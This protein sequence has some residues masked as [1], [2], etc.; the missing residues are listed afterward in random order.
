MVEPVAREASLYVGLNLANITEDNYPELR[1]DD[2]IPISWFLLFEASDIRTRQQVMPESISTFQEFENDLGFEFKFSDFMNEPVAFE[3]TIPKAQERLHKFKELFKEL[4]YFWSYFRVIDILEEHLEFQINRI[5][6]HNIEEATPIMQ[7]YHPD[8]IDSQVKLKDDIKSDADLM[9]LS[10]EDLTNLANLGLDEPS[11]PKGKSESSASEPNMD[12]DMMLD[13][14]PFAALMDDFSSALD[15]DAPEPEVQQPT[16]GFDDSFLLDSLGAALE[17]DTTLDGSEITEVAIEDDDEATAVMSITA[18]FDHLA[19]EGYGDKIHKIFERI[20]NLYHHIKREEGKITRIMIDIFQDIFR[21]SLTN[22]R[23][24]G[25]LSEDFV[26]G[27]PSILGRIMIG[28]PSAFNIKS[29]ITFDLEYWTRK[30]LQRG[31]ERLMFSLSKLPSEDLHDSI[32]N[33]EINE[34]SNIIEQTLLLTKSK[35]IPRYSQE[36]LK[37]KP[38]DSNIWG[39]R[40]LLPYGDAYT[41]ATLLCKDPEIT[42]KEDFDQ[43]LDLPGVLNDWNVEYKVRFSEFSHVD[44]YQIVF[45]R[46]KGKDETFIGFNRWIR[47]HHNLYMNKYG[48]D[49][50]IDLLKN[51]ILTTNDQMIG[52]SVFTILTNLSQLGFNKAIDALNDERL[53]SRLSWLYSTM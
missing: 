32:H 43:K 18:K 41:P 9:D 10:I 2:L 7:S 26:Q 49:G 51:K 3:T 33:N 30:T 23:I 39:I 4:P 38:K 5:A 15:M 25:L 47:I 14:N 27:D 13:D 1:S 11:Q 52:Q 48:I 42:W 29:G 6:E 31:D 35:K 44:D 21:D 20:D 45:K 40:V 46:A 37:K 19:I 17:L 36:N 34:V 12:T 16:E 8:V 22:W 24:T 53:M 28:T 50:T